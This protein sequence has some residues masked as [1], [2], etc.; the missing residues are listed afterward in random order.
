MDVLGVHRLF[1]LAA[2]AGPG[3]PGGPKGDGV[4]MDRR[5]LE[6]EALETLEA[7]NRAWTVERAPERLARFFHPEMVAITPADRE[8]RE[9]AAACIQGWSGFAGA[10]SIKSWRTHGEKV[11]LWGGG[12]VAVITYYYDM[13]WETQDGKVVNSGGR[14]MFVLAR[15]G[16]RWWAVADQF[17]PYPGGK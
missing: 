11:Q 8:R 2:F 15:E 3:F 14:D 17:S 12:S 6:A 13:S 16:G 4:S 5:R 7:L 1:T 10:V 9:G